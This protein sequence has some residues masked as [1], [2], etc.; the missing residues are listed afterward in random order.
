MQRHALGY[1]ALP[2]ELDTSNPHY[3]VIQRTAES[4]WPRWIRGLPGKVI[5]VAGLSDGLLA[6]LTLFCGLQG[7]RVYTEGGLLKR[8]IDWPL[9]HVVA[10]ILNLAQVS[11]QA[12]RNSSFVPG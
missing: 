9:S 4:Y 11:A 10:V 8:H 6:S 1:A 7:I 12:I 2:R 5:T 3:N